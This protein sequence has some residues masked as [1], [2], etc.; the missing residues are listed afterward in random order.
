MQCS[1]DRLC[2]VLTTQWLLKSVFSRHSLQTAATPRAAPLTASLRSV[3]IV[4]LLAGKCVGA[5]ERWQ[6]LPFSPQRSLLHICAASSVQELFTREVTSGAQSRSQGSLIPP[7]CHQPIDHFRSGRSLF[8]RLIKPMSS[9]DAMLL[10]M[11]WSL[12]LCGAV[13]LEG[14]T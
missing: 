5:E 14:K 2:P 3:R 9:L 6:Q 8:L 7:C 10:K 4:G 11:T 1:V 12:S 13:V